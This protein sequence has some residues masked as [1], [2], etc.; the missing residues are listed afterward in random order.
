MPFVLTHCLFVFSCLNPEFHSITHSPFKELILL[1]QDTSQMLFLLWNS[2][3]MFNWWV[4][5]SPLW[6]STHILAW[7]LYCTNIVLHFSIY[8]IVSSLY[9][10]LFGSRVHGLFMPVFLLSGNILSAGYVCYMAFPILFFINYPSKTFTK[11]FQAF[12]NTWFE[13]Y[14]I[15]II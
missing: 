3:F 14:V 10:R 1:I 4:S 11:S 7:I 6:V 8:F 12:S 13:H 9:C 2:N 5:C 15:I